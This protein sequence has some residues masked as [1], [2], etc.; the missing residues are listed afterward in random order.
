MRSYYCF[1]SGLCTG[2]VY[3]FLIGDFLFILNDWCP[4]NQ[5][6]V[7]LSSIRHSAMALKTHF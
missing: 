6:E 5:L 3:K 7:C 1:M 2:Y 4:V